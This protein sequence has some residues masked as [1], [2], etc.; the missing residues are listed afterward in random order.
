M[1]DLDKELEESMKV[2]KTLEATRT[3]QNGVLGMLIFCIPTL[4][5]STVLWQ[6]LK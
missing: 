3:L 1:R 6:W 2:L 4:T 5:I